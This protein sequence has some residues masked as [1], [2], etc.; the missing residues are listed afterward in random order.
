MTTEMVNYCR[1]L[2]EHLQA[3]GIP[4]PDV[5]SVSTIF[6]NSAPYVVIRWVG[7]GVHCALERDVLFICKSRAGI[8]LYDTDLSVNEKSLE[9][10]CDEFEEVWH[11]VHV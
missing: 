4:P 3:R 8:S 6:E 11:H 9:Q 1:D 7:H 10:V 2:V 5:F